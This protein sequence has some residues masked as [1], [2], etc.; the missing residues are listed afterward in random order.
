MT[1]QT[2]FVPTHAEVKRRAAKL[3]ERRRITGRQISHSQAI[4]RI[5]H[6]LGYRDWNTLSAIISTVRA[7]VGIPESD[8]ISGEYL[9]KPFRATLRK[10]G[11]TDNGNA[12]LVLRFDEPVGVAAFD[13]FS[14]E[15]KQIDCVVD[16]TGHSAERTSDGR[17]HVALDW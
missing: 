7:K 14:A 8:S 17:P 9:G 2:N 11:Q 3:R 12:R 4:E 5:A 15:R 1:R 16:A 13:G 10:I 6:A